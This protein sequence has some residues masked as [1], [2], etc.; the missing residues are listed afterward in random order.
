MDHLASLSHAGTWKR[1]IGGRD[2]TNG[3]SPTRE[4]PSLFKLPTF[5]FYWEKNVYNIIRKP[6]R[7][8]KFQN[9]SLVKVFAIITEILQEND[10]TSSSAKTNEYVQIERRLAKQILSRLRGALPVVCFRFGGKFPTSI[11]DLTLKGNWYFKLSIL[12]NIRWR[13]IYPF[14]YS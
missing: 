2:K 3:E 12:L 13:N 6:Q 11:R 10:L 5:G 8:A 14:S 1:P 9:S 4:Q 7:K